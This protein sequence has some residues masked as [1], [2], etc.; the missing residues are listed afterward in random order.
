MLKDVL[1][2]C[3]WNYGGVLLKHVLGIGLIAL[4]MWTATS[5]H[6]SLGEFGWFYA[7]FF[8]DSTGKLTH[9]SIYRFLNNPER[10]IGTAGL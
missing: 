6:E 9:K 4:Q 1:A 7:D 10:V 3:D 2:S 8:F 5:I